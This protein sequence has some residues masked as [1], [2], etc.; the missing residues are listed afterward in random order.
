MQKEE[1]RREIFEKMMDRKLGSKVIR[2]GT[3]GSALARKQTDMVIESLKS[4]F[5]DY[6]WEVVVLTTKGDKR[7]DVPITSFGGKAVFVEEIEQGACQ[8][9]RSTWQYIVQKICQIHAKRDLR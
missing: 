9:A 7:R 8:M 6:Q 3:R 1:E 4:T 2:I 5:P